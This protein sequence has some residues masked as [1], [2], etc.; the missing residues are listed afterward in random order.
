MSSTTPTQPE[1]LTPPHGGTLVDLMAN[2]ERRRELQALCR[3]AASWDLT[4]RQACDLELLLSGGFSP[5]RGF[6][7]EKDTESVASQMRLGDGTL[8]PMPINL[9]VPEATA[10][11]LA[12]GSP[13]ALRDGEGEVVAVLTVEEIFQPDRSSLAERVF[14]TLDTAH[15]GVAS[16]V[17]G[18]HPYFLS[19][20]LEGLSRP[21][22]HDFRAWRKTPAEV[23]AEH[24]PSR[25]PNVVAFQTRN[26]MHR[27]HVELTMR[28]ARQVHGTLLIH[29]VVGQTK[30][31]DVD[32]Y[33]R[34][35]CY[36][37]V[38]AN[39]PE[40][41]ARLALLPLAMRMGGPREALWHAIIRKNFG[42]SHFIVGRDHAG[43][44][45]DKAGRPFYGPYDAQ[46]LVR[47]HQAEIGIEMVPFRE[48]VYLADGDTF[49]PEDEIP[50]GASP[51][52]ISGTELRRLLQEGRP[53]PE[54]FTYP[55][56]ARELSR[57][58][59]PRARQGFTVFFT[60]LS[61]AGKSTIANVL[62]ARLLERGGRPVTLLDGDLVRKHL[63]AGLGFSR[64]DRDTNV[65]RVGWV[66]AEVSRH[67]GIVLCA[68]IAPY[69]AMR[70][71][72]RAMV[73]AEAAFVLVHV[74]TTVD[75]CEGRDRK[76]L[77]AKARAGNL[78]GF[79]GVTDPYEAPE[80]AEIVIQT[81]E[82]LP[83]DAA[84]RIVSYLETSG[85][86]ES[87]R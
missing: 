71:A 20:R 37:S 56:V 11:A 18:T 4:P 54:W 34:V 77:Y 30:P 10:Q 72:V 73:E 17:N 81:E 27:A 32:H 75:T 83:D 64:E 28:A 7:S 23:R 68:L 79:T 42:C 25:G 67:G 41:T 87:A 6:L 26:P 74:A 31:G 21:H 38:L 84:D 46:E 16:L 49:V 14:G 65:R 59:P 55:G 3:S 60:G 51:L 48:L 22:H 69:D 1:T 47:K 66:A 82:V 5:L 80:D 19:G 2:D 15:P 8:W 61:G 40:G 86:L 57:R 85:L 24:D 76:G 45:S 53:I 43:P 58:H 33:T 35:R 12:P 70:K 9:D 62:L 36:Q 50:E 52:R 78:P 29:P 44:G 63:T 39:Y 13:L